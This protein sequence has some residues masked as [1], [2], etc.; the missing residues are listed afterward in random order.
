MLVTAQSKLQHKFQQAYASAGAITPYVLNLD[1]LITMMDWEILL[2]DITQ[3]ISEYPD[4]IDTNDYGDLKRRCRECLE[5]LQD[6][7]T[8][9][10]PRSEIVENILVAFLNLGEYNY[11]ANFEKM[12]NQRYIIKILKFIKILYNKILIIVISLFVQVAFRGVH[13]ATCKGVS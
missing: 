10:N 11:V 12:Q 13:R 6:P 4:G 2:L 9:V 7:K 5:R 8:E 1:K 3:F